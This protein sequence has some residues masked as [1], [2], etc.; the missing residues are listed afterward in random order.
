[1]P[2][3]IFSEK[4]DADLDLF[5]DQHEDWFVKIYIDSGIWSAGEIL[6]NHAES[7]RNLYQMIRNT[8]ENKLGRQKVLGRKPGGKINELSFH[9]GSRLIII[10]F[11][12]DEI[13]NERWIESIFIN[14]KW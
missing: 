6:A 8:I 13:S 7:A 2:Q 14:K 10:L 1:M 12:D 3:V 9:I 5:I 11:S 4:A